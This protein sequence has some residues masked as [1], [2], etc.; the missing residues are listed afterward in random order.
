M[1]A[2]AERRT[3]PWACPDARQLLRYDA[4]RPLWLAERRNGIG[5]SDASTIA[6]V[7]RWS[8]RYE[9]YLDKTGRLPEEPESM[10]MRMGNL[11]EPIV[12]RLFTEET[13]I[14][15][16][17]AG[18]MVSRERPW[19]R[20]SVDGLTE[21]GGI[22]ECKTTNWRLSDEWEDGQ[23]ADH[24]EVQVQHALAV[25]GRTHAWVAV[26][27]D[28]HD[29]RWQRVERDEELIAT[30]VDL[31]RD[32]WHE[33][34]LADVPPPL[35]AQDIDVVKAL[36]PA[37]LRD[38]VE[39]DDHD[40][41]RELIAARAAGKAAEKAGKQ[42]ADV[43]E[44]ALIALVGDAEALTLDGRPVVTRK[45]TTRAGFTVAPTTYRRIHI[46]KEKS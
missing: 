28:G 27:I 31:E 10:A 35:E 33:H 30:L 25:T 2:V 46:A 21:D 13:G 18:L 4:P 16:R 12:L 44:A 41:V 3:R 24:A 7:N 11:L 37:V 8:S 42:A 19:Q 32:F 34:V 39:A 23:V 1:S 26:L 45:T 6:G 40:R 15:T 29:F 17:R 36:Y 22:A 5:G 14:A 20:V 43:A 9:L 38:V